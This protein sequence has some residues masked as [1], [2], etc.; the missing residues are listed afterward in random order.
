LCFAAL[1]PGGASLVSTGIPLGKT[2]AVVPDLEKHL[3]IDSAVAEEIA[4]E[5]RAR[6]YA[7]MDLVK[8]N[9]GL[10][11][12]DPPTTGLVKG[13]CLIVDFP[14]DHATIPPVEI[15]AYCNQVGYTGYVNNGSIRDYFY[16]ISDGHLTYTNFV[17]LVYYRAAN[18]KSYYDTLSVG[19]AKSLITEALEDLDASG[20]DFANP[21]YDAN[22]DG[23]LDAVNCYYAGSQG[24][25]ELWPHAYTISWSADGV[26][27]LRYQIT[28]MGD[29]LQIGI[30]CH[31]NG[32]SLCGWNDLY[33]RSPA[34]LDDS[35]GIGFFGL[36]CWVVW[37]HTNPQEPCAYH[38]DL[39]GWA[40]VYELTG[41]QTGMAVPAGINTFYRISHPSQANEYYLIENRHQ[42]AR[43]TGIPDEGLAIWHNDTWGRNDYQYMYPVAHYEVTLVQADGNWDLEHNINGGDTTDLWGAPDFMACTPYTS[44]NTSWWD[45]NPSGAFITNISNPAWIMTFD[46]HPSEPA[47]ISVAPQALTI[48]VA[49]G[50]EASRTLMVSNSGEMDLMW[51]VRE[52][53][54]GVYS[55][56]GGPD[57]FGYSWLSS[58]DP[59]GPAFAWRDITA[60]GTP[61]F[62]NDNSY[63]EVNLPFAFPFYGELKTEVKISSNGY[64]TFGQYGREHENWPTGWSWDS[65]A[66]CIAPFWTDLNPMFVGTISRRCSGP[67]AE[68]FSSIWK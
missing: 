3:R 18:S 19:G 14:D 15:A 62:L 21:I 37:P 10:E 58:D 6:H 55:A 25:D 2:D 63:Q 23:V 27:T 13:I 4:Q 46:F 5:N 64:L 34:G 51:T 30:F 26:S 31:E 66:D 57:A 32:H 49:S 16:D 20:F 59:G 17:P 60:E 65:V 1:A 8:Q 42:G 67:T 48:P 47:E 61:V 52:E 35:S 11:K 53:V 22:G 68:S 38:R 54:R 41:P 28:H 40:I 45:Q 36:M 7:D 50:S 44:P 43:D 33:D 29:E 39:A 56:S 9:L 24:L 12:S